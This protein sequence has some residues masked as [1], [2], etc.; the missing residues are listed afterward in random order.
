VPVLDLPAAAL[1]AAKRPAL[2]PRVRNAGRLEESAAS[3]PIGPTDLP[4]AIPATHKQLPS[5][6][7]LVFI[8]HDIVIR[9]FILSG[10]LGDLVRRHEVVFV[11]PEE[12]H[13]RVQLDPARLA[14]GAPYRR[15]AVPS[16]R[17]RLW[18]HLSLSHKLRWRAGR[19]AAAARRLERKMI[20]G[21]AALIFGALAL[22]GLH[23]LWTEHLEQRVRRQD[24]PAFGHLLAEERP[25]VMLHPSVLSGLFINDIIA[26]GRRHS[27]PTVVAMNSWDN[28][29]TKR[30]AVDQPDWLLVWGEQTRQHGI[31]LVGM[32]PERVAVLGAAQFDAFSE[33]PRVGRAEFCRR[34]DIDPGNAVLLYAGASKGTDEFADLRDLDDAIEAGTLR[35][36]AIVYRPHPW[37]AGGK[38]GA[39][40]V[41]HPWRHVRLDCTMR[42]Y[43][44]DLQRG[45]PS[46]STPDYRNTH[47]LLCAVDAVVS[48]L[49]T[50]L[51]EA[52]LHGKPAL[53]FLRDAASWRFRWALSLRHFEE[54]FAE[55]AF[56][57]ERDAAQLTPAVLSLMKEARDPSTAARYRAAAASFVTSFDRPY[58][59]RLAEFIETKALA[60]ARMPAT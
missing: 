32:A 42:Q 25:D 51:L 29:C 59:E 48:P 41:K 28:P 49:S 23:M 39:R 33:Q 40:I 22:P 15:L 26:F 52:A 3:R 60:G 16:E 18:Q 6:K 21:K 45:G 9:H 35:H 14:L 7:I 43:L 57:L 5:V 8:D 17:L 44:E 47:D 1:E 4:V 46:I 10:A 56:R 19:H 20:G 37:G 54:F 31:D 12:G 27:I 50:M 2:Q 53:C 34:H 38:D 13:R 24:F 11:F 30:G 36:V 55:P 58:A